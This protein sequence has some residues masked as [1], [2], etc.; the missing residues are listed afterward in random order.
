MPLHSNSFFSYRDTGL[1]SIEQLITN[2][3]TI[4]HII[5]E[6]SGLADPGNLAP[7][8]WVDDGLGS[9]I[10]LDGIVT[11]VDVRN[12]ITSLDESPPPQD[13]E[14]RE[15]LTTAHLQISHADVLVVNKADTVEEGELK[16]VLERIRSINGMAKVH[17]TKYSQ[18]PE[19]EGFLL[20]IHAYEGVGALY[21]VPK[22][23]SHLDPVSRS[24]HSTLGH[25]YLDVWDK[26]TTANALIEYLNPLHPPSDPD[27]L[28]TCRPRVLA[29]STPLG[30]QTPSPSS[31]LTS[32][33]ATA[34][35]HHA[36]FITVCSYS[37]VQ[38]TSFLDP[39]H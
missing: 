3:P 23:H 14:H 1:A 18:V 7:L 15:H 34:S 10:Y 31:F 17:V 28:S 25:T 39:P 12:I 38:G 11:L 29:P 5:L 6:T 16:A 35:R 4:T 24:I 2:N 8:F 32:Y 36:F 19:L 22:A 27:T 26:V 9:S 30:K 33:E 37:T 21:N 13:S 20:D